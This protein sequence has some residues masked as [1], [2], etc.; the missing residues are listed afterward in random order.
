VI[1]YDK[2]TGAPTE[3]M[4]SKGTYLTKFETEVYIS[5]I[6]GDRSVEYFDEFVVEYLVNGG[7]AVNAEVNAWYQSIN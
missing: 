4:L 5:I 1:E 2:F 6:M 3:S 7:L